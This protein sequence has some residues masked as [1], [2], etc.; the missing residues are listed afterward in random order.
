MRHSTRFRPSGRIYGFAAFRCGLVIRRHAVM[1]PC[2][3]S[4]GLIRGLSSGRCETPNFELLF[5]TVSPSLSRPVPQRTHDDQC[6]IHIV[7]TAR[8]SVAEKTPVT[9]GQTTRSLVLYMFTSSRELRTWV[10]CPLSDYELHSFIYPR[11]Q[12]FLKC[13]ASTMNKTVFQLVADKHARI[14]LHLS[15][16]TGS[17]DCCNPRRVTTPHFAALKDRTLF[18]FIF[19]TLLKA[20]PRARR[21]PRVFVQDLD[22]ASFLSFSNPGHEKIYA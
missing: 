6:A 12:S 14:C 19:H 18:L 13:L 17:N 21:R 20:G 7:F 5:F 2:D 11:C 1:H 4:R 9:Q 22:G 8:R 10:L 15:R 16:A 3:S